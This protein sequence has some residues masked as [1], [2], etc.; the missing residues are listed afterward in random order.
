MSAWVGFGFAWAP[1]AAQPFARTNATASKSSASKS[2]S[3]PR[4][5][6]EQAALD[7]FTGNF[8]APGIRLRL[9]PAGA[10]LAGSINFKDSQY[11]V[12][13]SLGKGCL[14]GKFEDDEHSWPFTATSDGKELLF[15]TGTV[16]NK[17][18]RQILGKWEGVFQSDQAWLKM[19]NRN[20][21]PTGLLKFGG[22]EYP[23]TGTIESDEIQASFNDSGKS[24]PIILTS[25]DGGLRLETDT[26]SEVLK[27]KSR[28]GRLV[29]HAKAVSDYTLLVDGKRV[30]GLNG[31]YELPEEKPLTLELQAPGCQPV[32]T[33][34]SLP[35]YSETIWEAPLEKTTFPGASTHRWTNELGMIFVPVPK[36]TVLFSIWDTRVQDYL[37]FATVTKREW[38]RPEFE[39]GNNHPVVN[40]SWV[41][42]KAF[43]DWLTQT[44]RLSG[45]IDSH[46]SYRL[47]TDLEWS[48]A[49]GLEEP[50]VATP[51]D[52]DSIIIGQYPWGLHW[53]PLKGA[54]N[55]HPNLGVDDYAN[56]SPVGAFKAND[57]GL[58]DLGGNVWQWCE[59]WYDTEQKCRVLRGGSWIN[60]TSERLQTSFRG[61]GNLPENRY[62]NTGFRC[63][64]TVE[65][66][67]K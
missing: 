22:H 66:T 52:R 41:D 56:T 46:Q 54:G 59:D 4:N 30:N 53:P 21:V 15:A 42:A 26:Y 28:A 11:T 38:K 47:P 6:F 12:K 35:A 23:F 62:N 8:K 27:Q 1:L 55:F 20:G 25:E 36:T 60:G 67:P 40:V 24:R 13:A 5:P 32:K 29:V 31:L 58:F 10:G 3:P 7:V 17:F 43:C 63:V 14:E 45:R 61:D 64:L 65:A 51:K 39:Q 16:T 19:E 18:T 9:K 2:K 50:A 34:L 57:F 48:L 37:A 49:A 44:G 33:N